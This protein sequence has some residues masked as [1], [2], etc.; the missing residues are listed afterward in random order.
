MIRRPPRSTR[1]DTLFPYTTL[2]RSLLI[3]SSVPLLLY[4]AYHAT[5]APVQANWIVPLQA[6]FAIPAAFGLAQAR[7]PRLWSKVTI[8]IA[9]LMSVGLVATAF[10]PVTPIGTADN[11]PNQ[12][13]GW[14]ATQENGRASCRERVC[15]YG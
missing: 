5:H 1:T 14:P 12:T 7:S 13:P 10:N 8:A 11:P 2:F 3:W 15:T 6:L 9:L 4:F